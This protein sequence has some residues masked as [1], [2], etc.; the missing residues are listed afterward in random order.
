MKKKRRFPLALSILLPTILAIVLGL[1]GIYTGAYFVIQDSSYQA[2]ITNDSTDLHTLQSSFTSNEDANIIGYA[3]SPIVKK[4]EDNKPEKAFVTGSIEEKEYVATIQASAFTQLYA[5][6]R[7][8]L[9]RYV[10]TFVGIFY[11]D[12]ATNRFVLICSSDAIDDVD[13]V[14]TT[15][16][17]IGAFFEKPSYAVEEGFYGQTV[18]DRH[19]GKL[20]VSGLYLCEVAHPVHPEDYD[21]AHRYWLFRET[22]VGEVYAAMSRFTQNFAIV[23]SILLVV[24]TGIIALLLYLLIINPLH[25]LSKTGNEYVASLKEGK[26]EELFGLSKRRTENEISDLNN[27]LYFTQEA[28]ADYSEKVRQS[29]IFEEKI[30][31]DLALAERIQSSMVPST[32]LIGENFLIRGTMKPAKEVGGDLYNYFQIDEDHVGF[33]VGDVSGKGVPAALF[34]AKANMLLRLAL[35]DLDVDEAN[36]ILCED[37]AEN[38]FVTAFLAVLNVKTGWLHYV[39]CGHEP[40]FLGHNG[41]YEPL[42]EEANLML[43]MDE[44]LKFVDQ[45]IKLVPGDRLFLYTDGVSEA[46]DIDGKLFGKERIREALNKNASLPSEP[47]FH[48]MWEAVADFVKTAEQSD[49]ACMVSLDYVR[50]R[51]LIFE[52]TPEGLAKVEPFIDDFLEGKDMAFISKIQVIMDELCSN[53]VNYSESGDKPVMLVLRDDGSSIKGTLVDQGIQFDPLTDKPEHDEN[54]AGGL[55]ILMAQSM[56]DEITHTYVAKRNI[57][58]F[59]KDYK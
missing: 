40:V 16:L 52:A 48:A 34:M 22:A 25:R 27:S 12:T 38:F 8:R 46:M 11:E 36:K 26:P 55:G 31:A 33:V 13:K 5:A 18:N 45:K 35:K 15:S 23:A 30:N 14:D 50:E 29:A 9:Q 47:R 3:C 56:L 42:D 51:T 21:G 7:E 44:D 20:L 2:A 43:G 59:R 37:N 24:L 4:Y 28:I 32:P 17:Y 6:C 58:S 53:V 10:T 1:G 19:L 54:E 57:L 39:N 49:D 41:V